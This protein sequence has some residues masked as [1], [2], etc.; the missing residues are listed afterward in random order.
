MGGRLRSVAGLILLL[1]AVPIFLFGLLWFVGSV[2]VF[3]AV[4]PCLPDGVVCRTPP[5]VVIVL[6]A[7]VVVIGVMHA[8]VGVGILRNSF[9]AMVGGVLTSI[10]GLA[11]TASFAMTAFEP[12]GTIRHETLGMVPHYDTG[13][14]AIAAGLLP[15]A[16]LLIILLVSLRHSAREVTTSPIK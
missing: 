14:L 13:R 16:L 9:R 6:G 8:A 12:V 15:Y 3:L 2:G 7:A 5:P 10:G 11:V 1:L 4:G